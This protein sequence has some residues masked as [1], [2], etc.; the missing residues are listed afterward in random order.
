MPFDSTSIP[1][2]IWEKIF[3]RYCAGDQIPPRSL[4]LVCRRWAWL[5]R[6]LATLW[7]KLEI[8]L[9][10]PGSIAVLRD[11]LERRLDLA[12]GLTLEVILS[13][14]LRAG[15][16]LLRDQ[17]SDLFRNIV[18]TKAPPQRWHSLSVDNSPFFEAAIMGSPSIFDKAFTALRIFSFRGHSSSIPEFLHF[19]QRSNLPLERLHL[20]PWYVSNDLKRIT[21]PPTLIHLSANLEV[22]LQVTMPAFVRELEITRQEWR[23]YFLGPSRVT[24]PSTVVIRNCMSNLFDHIDMRNVVALH[25]DR[26]LLNANL[27]LD[28]PNLRTLHI[29]PCIPHYLKIFNAPNLE[30]MKLTGCHTYGLSIPQKIVRQEI[31]ACS[32]LLFRKERYLLVTRPESLTI[33]V[34]GI[35]E[36]TLIAMLDAWPQLKHLSLT[37]HNHFD[38]AGMFARRLQKL[39]PQLETIY[40]DTWWYGKGRKWRKWRAAAKSVMSARKDGP[41]EKIIWRNRWFE[42]ES[43]IRAAT[44]SGA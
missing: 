42:T 15:V 38:L 9:D 16:L 28:L 4:A 6:N 37:I 27:T 29:Q 20:L 34:H 18:R 39:C 8:D 33:E 26:F 23:P 22:I 12:K 13:N 7:R 5:L 32:L 1:Q 14:T 25:L 35:T 43:V 24:M 41:L 36:G 21:L 44:I 19:M 2:E 31:R 11:R 30:G 10:A 40:I 17:Y 3:E